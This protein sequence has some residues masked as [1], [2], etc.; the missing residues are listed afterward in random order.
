MD[1]RERLLAILGETLAPFAD[2]IPVAMARELVHGDQGYLAPYQLSSAL[3]SRMTPAMR[4]WQ[5]PDVLRAIYPD[6]PLS[7]TRM[8]PI[9][10]A[11]AAIGCQAFPAFCHF[12]YVPVA[13][14]AEGR[15]E[16][17]LIIAVHGSSRNAKD[18]RDG[19]AA[20]AE[21]LG[22]FVLAP[23][24]PMDLDMAVPDEEY[25]QLVGDRLRYDRIV[26]AMVEELSAVVRTRF[27]KIL[28]FGFSGGAQF[29]QRL[30]Y[31][32]PGRLAAV[33][34]GAPTYVTLPS[35]AWDWWSGLG[36]FESVF[37]KAVDWDALRR[38]PVQLQC[39]TE[40]RLDC[41]IYSAREMAMDASD[42]AAYGRTR[43]E[44]IAV[45]QR[46][47]EGTG[48][49]SRIAMIPGAAHAWLPHVET[50]KPF[51]ETILTASV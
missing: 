16:A 30:L 26:W 34:L 7:R 9:A 46:H 41:D 36:D 10:G 27:S 28:L 17:P 11:L 1:D 8:Q 12:P 20:F 47:Y 2:M 42:F 13:H 24:F 38:V 43:I 6:T 35:T 31:V 51:F 21:R 19:F 40:D 32:D 33:A 48:I 18:L 50:A 3:L 4:D 39:G 49:P 15:D 23:L 22:C 45:L 25:K 14:M 44:R 37:G 5:T 29:A